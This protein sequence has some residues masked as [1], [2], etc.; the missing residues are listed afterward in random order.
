MARI[1]KNSIRASIHDLASSLYKMGSI[2]KKTMDHYDK[3]CLVP[4]K[5]Y[6]SGAIR[7]LRERMRVSQ[8]AFAYYLNVTKGTISQWER[9]I[10]HPSGT[11]LKL[12]HIVEKHGLSALL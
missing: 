12:L 9:G 3:A 10:K 8:Q 1:Y 11:S 7:K 6:S 2:D 4:L 5:P